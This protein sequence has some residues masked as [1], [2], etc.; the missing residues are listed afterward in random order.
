MTPTT[1][2]I[3]TANVVC[4]TGEY[5]TGEPG[6]TVPAGCAAGATIKGGIT[7]RVSRTQRV[8]PNRF[9]TAGFSKGR[10]VS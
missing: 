2:V 5:A 10:T 8:R 9:V 7:Y 3:W 6:R 4:G 1:D